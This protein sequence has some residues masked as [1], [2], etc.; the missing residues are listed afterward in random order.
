MRAITVVGS[1]NLDLVVSGAPLPRAGETVVGG[2]FRASPGGKG[3]NQAVAIA[4]LGGDA[5]FVGCVGDD[6]FG[7]AARAALVAAGVDVSGLRVVAKPT[8]VALVVVDADGQNQISVA[9][10]ANDDVRHDGR[11]DVVLTQLETPAAEL[12][13]LNPAPA[14]DVDLAGVDWVV[15][16]ELE[17][18]QLTGQTDPAR[19]KAA[20]EA[21][22]ARH[23]LITLGARGVFDGALRPAFRVRAVDTVGAG[24]AFVGAF[25]LA[26][27]EGW[28]DPVRFAQAVAAL[29]VTRPGAQSVPNREETL[30]FLAR[31]GRRSSAGG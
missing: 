2:A 19:Q 30:A 8:G 29:Q 12:V 15:P 26:L 14:R 21:R 13:V 7:R 10:G 1:L 16:N 6:A 4:R 9:L 3:A 23:A 18:R 11:H 17:A 28:P 25:T 5:R 22:G 27:A 24:D 31:A 20:L